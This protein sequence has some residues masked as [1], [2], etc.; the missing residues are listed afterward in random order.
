[1]R[2]EIEHPKYVNME[3]VTRTDLENLRAQLLADIRALLAETSILVNKPW[4]RGKEVKRLL[5][6]SE[7][8]LQHLRVTGQLTAS[9]IGGIYYYRYADIEKMMAEAER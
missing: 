4:L 5:G 1:M 3:H 2:T 9:R 6:I 8:S 7:G